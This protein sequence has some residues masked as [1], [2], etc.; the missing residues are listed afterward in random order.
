VLLAMTGY[1]IGLL[2][3][4]VVFILFALLVAL[5]VP[6]ARP[7]FPASRLGIFIAV[8][9]V[10]FAAQMGAVVALAEVGEE[11]DEPEAAETTLTETTDTK[12]TDTTATTETIP[13]ETTDTD[14]TGTETTD[15]GQPSGNGGDPVAGQAVFA[16]AGCV[17]CHTLADAGATG[18]IGPNLDEASP[19]HDLVVERVTFGQ[20]AMPSFQDTLREEQIQDVAAY[21]SSA[22]GS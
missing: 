21:V 15:T 16:S 8:C 7:D 10:L 2:S 13:T 17:S 18:T 5:V 4:A 19:S 22:A 14:T 1:E 6:R 3:V 9:V 11:H 12:P 20:G